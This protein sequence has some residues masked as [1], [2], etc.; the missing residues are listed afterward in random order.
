M[1]LTA[2]QATFVRE[3]LV[4]K[5]AT[6]AAV[7]SGYSPKTAESQGSRLLRNAKVAEAVAAGVDKQAERTGI[8]A[9]RVLE[10]LAKIAFV[11]LTPRDEDDEDEE[12]ANLALLV[13]V[14]DKLKAL[15]LLGKHLRLFADKVEHEGTVS[16]SIVDPYA[17]GSGQSDG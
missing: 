6:Q 7:R 12:D 8:T 9:D 15:E 11:S 4:D 1:A 3:Y 5:N 16:I 10:E 14:P 2:K 17:T 13:R